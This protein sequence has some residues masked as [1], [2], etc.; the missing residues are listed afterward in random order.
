MAEETRVVVLMQPELRDT[1]KALGKSQGRVLM[2]QIE[3]ILKEYVAKAGK[4]TK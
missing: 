3:H 4:A 1:L 2:R